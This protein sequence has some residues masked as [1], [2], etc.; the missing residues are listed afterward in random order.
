M[1]P[2]HSIRLWLLAMLS[3][4]VLGFYDPA[5]ASADRRMD[6]A[7][8]PGPNSGNRPDVSHSL[9]ASAA[10]AVTITEIID[11]SGDGVGNTLDTAG[12]LASAELTITFTKVFDPGNDTLPPG[13]DVADS[14]LVPALDDGTVA[15]ATR[16]TGSGF[17]GV[18]LWHG[19]Q[20]FD[21]VVDEEDISTYTMAKLKSFGAP[22][23]HRGDT[24]FTSSEAGAN[25]PHMFINREIIIVNEI[26]PNTG[27][28]RF[29]A[30]G[31]PS[32]DH[33][34]VAFIGVAVG[35][36]GLWYR[37]AN[38]SLGSVLVEN[39]SSPDGSHWASAVATQLSN[40]R[41]CIVATT[42]L[43]AGQAV[44]WSAELGESVQFLAPP[45]SGVASDAVG[46]TRCAIDGNE[47]AF[48]AGTPNP[49]PTYQ[50]VFLERDGDFQLLAST[51][52][53]PDFG[54]TPNAFKGLSIDAGRV[55]VGV[56]TA[57]G[58][59][60]FIVDVDG[61]LHK[62]VATNDTIELVVGGP[63]MIG[64]PRI[65]RDAL[66][67]NSLAF[68][69][70]GSGSVYLATVTEGLAARPGCDSPTVACIPSTTFGQI[71][72]LA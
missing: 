68:H 61:S 45:T 2:V 35:L 7:D 10:S 63:D 25:I 34:E 52:A 1:I 62:V 16:L 48:V 41:V 13:G 5:A 33:A 26:A 21:F 19:S 70:S 71:D 37:L 36:S 59:A 65:L 11:A 54:F 49:S 3:V 46:F 42:D 51:E 44:L 18:Y 66:S 39:Q 72:G 38:G 15:F 14:T 12:L 47:I 43:N 23:R 30:L 24:A 29:Q 67:G 22:S 60:I 20:P 17:E 56:D 40:H 53:F 57:E 9:N 55:A 4:A 58:S 8:V 27:G 69:D 6:F 50:N 64:T 28:N 31:D 32:L